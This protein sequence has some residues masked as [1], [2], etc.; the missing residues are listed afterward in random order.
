VPQGVDWLE[1][2]DVLDQGL[3]PQVTQ[4]EG[5]EH[6]PHRNGDNVVNSL[7]ASLGT[8]DRKHLFIKYRK[9]RN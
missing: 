2:A 6:D 5:D 9:K 4:Q 1:D 3:V 8:K 7:L